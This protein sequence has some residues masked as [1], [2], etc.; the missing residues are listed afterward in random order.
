MPA[1]QEKAVTID[2]YNTESSDMYAGITGKNKS[3]RIDAC[4]T[5][6]K[7]DNSCMHHRITVTIDAGITEESS[8]S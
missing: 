5:A 1:P 4:T 2:T 3:V 6:E 7:S 8:D